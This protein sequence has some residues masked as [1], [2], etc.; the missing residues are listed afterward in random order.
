VKFH[1]VGLRGKYSNIAYV[2]R[3]ACIS[4]SADGFF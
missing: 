4:A 1:G 3:Q 2:L